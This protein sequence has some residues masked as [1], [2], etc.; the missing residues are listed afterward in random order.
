LHSGLAA[1]GERRGGEPAQEAAGLN[2][3]R[4]AA[5]GSPGSNDPAP[6]GGAKAAMCLAARC[7][8]VFRLERCARS[9]IRRASAL[10]SHTFLD[11]GT[12]SHPIA[13]S[14]DAFQT[15]AVDQRLAPGIDRIKPEICDCEIVSCRTRGAAKLIV[16]RK[17]LGDEAILVKPDTTFPASGSRG[18]RVPLITLRQVYDMH[19]ALDP[20]FVTRNRRALSLAGPGR[21]IVRSLTQ[22]SR[23]CLRG[24]SQSNKVT[25]H[26]TTHSDLE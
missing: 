13:T 12:I 2:A 17:E 23:S 20:S 22:I 15:S 26:P 24:H 11:A 14:G 8:S 1:A 5:A 18:N 9:G 4:P 10:K 6:F 3:P 25:A 7:A 16:R 19:R 21:M